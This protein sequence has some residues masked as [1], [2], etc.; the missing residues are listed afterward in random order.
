MYLINNLEEWATVSRDHMQEML[1]IQAKDFNKIA[2]ESIGK[3]I[4]F[5]DSRKGYL[6][7]ADQLR[8]IYK[9]EKTEK[10]EDSNRSNSS[11]LKIV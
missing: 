8:E 6:N 5:V 9:I 7:I 2:I 3:I 4:D 10:K 1:N 11:H